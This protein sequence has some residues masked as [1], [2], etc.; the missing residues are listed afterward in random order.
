[1]NYITIGS[2][3]PYWM[4]RDIING[5]SVLLFAT[6]LYVLLSL[7]PKHRSL[8]DEHFDEVLA[9]Y[10][11]NGDEDDED[12]HEHGNIT[13]TPPKVIIPTEEAK[14]GEPYCVVCRVNKP[15]CAM[16]PCLHQNYCGECCPK[17]SECAICR[18]SI[19]GYGKVYT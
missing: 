1:M 11:I 15:D 12:D 13:Y 10:I 18:E 3:G 16:M 8:C 2:Y 5:A 4:N 14:E 19:T 6:G 7:V 9:E 17:L